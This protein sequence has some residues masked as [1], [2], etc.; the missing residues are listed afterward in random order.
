MS[1]IPIDPSLPESPVDPM[2]QG[3]ITD[4]DTARL[5]ELVRASSEP[6]V[7][8]GKGLEL[9]DHDREQFDLI[10][11]KVETDLEPMYKDPSWEVFTNLA[12]EGRTKGVLQ[13]QTWHEGTTVPTWCVDGGDDPTVK[14]I[15]RSTDDGPMPGIQVPHKVFNLYHWQLTADLLRVYITRSNEV[16]RGTAPAQLG[17]ALRH[18]ATFVK[19]TQQSQQEKSE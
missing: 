18:L 9:T 2:S 5:N 11:T 7:Y 1:E 12:D 6:G 8:F 16:L 14:K 13:S 19:H 17:H 3:P 10:A 15:M 4:L